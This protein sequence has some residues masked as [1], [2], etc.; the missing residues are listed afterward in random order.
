MPRRSLPLLALLVALPLAAGGAEY[1]NAAVVNGRPITRE[2]LE[3]FFED[4]AAEKGRSPTSIWTP[5]PLKRLRREALDQLVQ[6]E[7]LWQECERKKLIAPQEEVDKALEVL[8]GKFKTREAYLRRLER[9]GFD[10]KGYAEFV[11]KQLS[12]RKLVEREVTSGVAVS[13]AEMHDLYESRPDQFTEPPEA[14]LRHILIK[15]EERASAPQR[16]KARR[17]AE[18]VLALA[19]KKGADFAAL[20]KAHSEDGSS[21]SGGDLGFVRPAQMVKP[22]EDAAFALA[23]GEIS[24]VVE[25]VYGFHVIQCLERRGGG[26]I[27]ESAARDQLRQAIFAQKAAQALDEKVQ[28]LKK[29]ARIEIL[30]SL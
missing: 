17:R 2:R 22:F 15:A 20:A 11:K 19:R 23:P 8:R 5:E 13:D 7:L 18:K 10:E 16:K 21:A 1:G 24:G 3:R 30:L 28:A 6:Q 25:T 29:T 26:R 27:P 14:H 9:G 12:I 4:Y